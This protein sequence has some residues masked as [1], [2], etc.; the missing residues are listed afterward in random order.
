VLALLLPLTRSLWHASSSLAAWLVDLASHW[1][2]L[3]AAL[4][5]LVILNMARKADRRRW[6]VCLPL[7]C[8]P[9]L[10]AAPR[11]PALEERAAGRDTLAEQLTLAVA[12][13]HVENTDSAPLARWLQEKSPDVLIVLE[14]SPDYARQMQALYPY[15]HELPQHSPFGL[16]IYSRRPLT[17]LAINTN[18]LDVPQ[19][20]ATLKLAGRDVRVVAFHPMP[21]LAPEF[22]AERDHSF[23]QFVQFEA[24]QLIGGDLNASPWSSAFSKLCERPQSCLRRVTSLQPTWPSNGQGIFGIPIDHVLASAHFSRVDS[25]LG[26]NIGSDHRPV[27]ATVSF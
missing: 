21:P 26:P 22:H 4:L 15:R 17:E 2:W 3:W 11:L 1:Q 8:L 12:N 14:L 9:W 19:L 23:T 10:T 27:W 16:G 18:D 5:G 24:P 6:L 25:G 13:V 7:V 20:R